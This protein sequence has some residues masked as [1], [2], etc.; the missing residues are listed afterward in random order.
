MDLWTYKW[1]LFLSLY[2]GYRFYVFFL[3]FSFIREGE[4]KSPLKSLVTPLFF[5]SSD[6]NIQYSSADLSDITQPPLPWPDA[7]V[8]SRLLL[9]R[10]RRGGGCS[11]EGPEDNIASYLWLHMN[12]FEVI[13]VTLKNICNLG[14]AYLMSLSE[15]KN[16]P[17]NSD[18]L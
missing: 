11:S 4:A 2:I 16:R 17:A 9:P 1:S 6:F 13:H 14:I 12:D 18:T 10:W 8:H 7:A 15:R 5:L 3:P